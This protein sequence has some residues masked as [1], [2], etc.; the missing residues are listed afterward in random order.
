LGFFE[1]FASSQG[2]KKEGI[3]KRKKKKKDL[4]GSGIP[5]TTQTPIDIENPKRDVNVKLFEF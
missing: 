4:Q 2:N 3:D 1:K 5:W